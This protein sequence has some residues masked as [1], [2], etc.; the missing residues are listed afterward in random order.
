MSTYEK[1]RR[2]GAFTTF[3]GL[4]TRYRFVIARAIDLPPEKWTP[5]YA[6]LVIAFD[7]SEQFAPRGIAIGVFAVVDQFSF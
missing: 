7:I 3:S 6:A 2:S 1:P 4:S 5:G